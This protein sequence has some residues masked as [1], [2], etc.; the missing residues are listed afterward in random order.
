VCGEL[1][2]DDNELILCDHVYDNGRI[3]RSQVHQQCYAS[4]HIDVDANVFYCDIH[5][6]P[7]LFNDKR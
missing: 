5:R 6:D 1:D 7:S 2:T 3:C 4:K